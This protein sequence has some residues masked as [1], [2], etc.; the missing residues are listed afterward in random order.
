MGAAQK[1][2]LVAITRHGARNLARLGADL[3]DADLF[4][5]AKFSAE[6]ESVPNSVTALTPPFRGAIGELFNNY[7][8]L[9][10]LFSIGAAVRLIAPYLKSKEEDPGVLVI[11]DAGRFVIP[12]LSGHQGGANA[13]AEQLAKLIDAQAVM[14]TASES[15][16]TLP[17]D[18][19]GRELGWKTDAPKENLVSVAADVVNGEP[20][21]FIQECGSTQ[22]W[23]KPAPLPANI[24]CFSRFE[25]V[26]LDQFKSLLWVTRQE[27]PQSLR[28]QLSGHLVIYRPPG[29][30]VLGI[31][32]DRDTTLVTIETA[33]AQ[34]LNL[35]GLNQQQIS[36]IATIDK[37]SDEAGLL[38]LAE[39]HNWPL[40]FYS[41]DELSRVEVPN[42][43][44]TVLKYMGTPSV[45]EAAALLLAN[46]D[47]NH[48]VVEKHK[49]RGPDDRNA[50][51]SIAT[52]DSD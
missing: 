36:A 21:A 19:L 29:K 23:N 15:L 43:S 5:S 40:H 32:C 1:I 8:Q 22:W 17:V 10:L 11:D 28:D 12:I 39:K 13:F 38:A 46:A 37:K 33:L 30:I 6:L 48:L 51:I 44:E 7:D 27:V 25:E 42:P 24:H 47:K 35:A 4:V 26:D 20:I 49:Y 41:A 9:V 18:I 31:G 3:P 52:I 45:G 14:T 2:A 34:A 50:T 16:G